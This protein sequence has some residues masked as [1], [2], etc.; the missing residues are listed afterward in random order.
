MLGSIK[1]FLCLIAIILSVAAQNDVDN[2]VIIYY[3]LKYDYSLAEQNLIDF[4]ILK[5]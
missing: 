4:T 3:I 5:L 1:E 2:E